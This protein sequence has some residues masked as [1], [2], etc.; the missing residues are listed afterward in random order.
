VA[1]ASQGFAD[2]RGV[3]QGPS[4]TCLSDDRPPVYL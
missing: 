1:V 3:W 2:P 4:S